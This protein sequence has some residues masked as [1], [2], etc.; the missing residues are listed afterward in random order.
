MFPYCV[1]LAHE[2]IYPAY[3][4]MYIVHLPCIHV[5]DIVVRLY[6]SYGAYNITQVLSHKIRNKHC[7]YTIGSNSPKHCVYMLFYK[8]LSH[9]GVR[10][11]EVYDVLRAWYWYLSV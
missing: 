1:V 5:R 2:N 3:N 9:R 8:Y 10:I 6:L 11:R 7:M 4:N